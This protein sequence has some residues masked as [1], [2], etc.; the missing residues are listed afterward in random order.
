MKDL[1]NKWV[2]NALVLWFQDSIDQMQK[3][4]HI[5]VRSNYNT[6]WLLT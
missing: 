5:E 4:L 1:S 2:V 6:F 3:N